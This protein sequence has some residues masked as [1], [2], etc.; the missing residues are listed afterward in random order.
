MNQDNN[1]KNQNQNKNRLNMPRNFHNYKKMLSDNKLSN[2][3]KKTHMPPI[4]PSQNTVNEE[5]IN[6]N[7][8]QV[9]KSQQTN[10]QKKLGTSS[11][12]PKAE[13]VKGTVEFVKTAAK[14]KLLALLAPAIAQIS[15]IFVAALL[16]FII[17]M[18]PIARLTQ[19]GESI[20]GWWANVKNTFTSFCLFCSDEEKAESEQAKRE[21]K[22]YKKINK[23]K[24]AFIQ[25]KGMKG[26]PDNR[27]DDFSIELDLALLVSSILYNEDLFDSNVEAL[28]D[29]INKDKANSNNNDDFNNNVTE[30]NFDSWKENN[31]QYLEDLG[32]GPNPTFQTVKEELS[33]AQEEMEETDIALGWYEAKGDPIGVA[34]WYEEPPSPGNKCYP[35]SYSY[36]TKEDPAWASTARKIAKHMVERT[37][38][39][40]CDLVADYD[41]ETGELIGYHWEKTIE[42][43]YAL[44]IEEEQKLY[45]PIVH[46]NPY[47]AVRTIEE[48]REIPH[49]N[50]YVK[51]MLSTYIP[52]KYTSL[53]KDESIVS[54]EEYITSLKIVLARVYT[55][56]DTYEQWLKFWEEESST[57]IA[58]TG[59]CTYKFT[60][61]E[62]KTIETSNLKVR[63]LECKAPYEP[64]EG[65][66]L[67]DFEKYILGV[68]Y[69]ENGGGYTEALKAQAIAARNFSLK[70]A[71]DGASNHYFSD[72][73]T[74]LNISNCTARQVYCDPDK[75]CWS[76]SSSAGDT[77][78]S[79]QNASKAYS[80]G[81]V[82]EKVRTAVSQVT[83]EVLVNAKGEIIGTPYTAGNGQT[84][85]N[86]MANEGKDYTE[87]LT[88]WYSEVREFGASEII[89]TSCQSGFIAGDWSSWK[90]GSGSP[91]SNIK[92]CNASA[93]TIAQIGCA[94]TSVS[95]LIAGSG[96]EIT[97]P[98][99]NPGTFVK[100]LKQNG[101]FSGCAIV[102]DAP[103]TT[104]IAPNFHFISDV[105]LSGS[106]TQ[107]VNKISSYLNDGYYL[108]MGVNDKH[109]GNGPGHYVAVNNVVNETVHT[110]DPGGINLLQ[111]VGP[112]VTDYSPNSVTRI[113]VYKKND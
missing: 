102:W 105:R 76:N 43:D 75:G 96:T 81:A 54:T 95:I 50:P 78:H 24:K 107:K 23:I 14:K 20:N 63:L 61:E 29:T 12:F 100:H 67:V 19:A 48:I 59:L 83:G 7:Q 82:S 25:G 60:T 57:V 6:Q 71:A 97:V 2:F 33:K 80:K 108:V 113:L 51:Y 70:G 88:Y 47:P 10:K 106:W 3:S 55:Y 39:A 9:E 85:W 53:L 112:I 66:E 94:A 98:D 5:E 111:I 32:F 22:F 90:Q 35:L 38:D 64:I 56:R 110:Y 68:V 65:E 16:V 104:G 69:A 46:A 4:L 34:E 72:N 99:F 87:I 44:R 18:T 30:E 40:D 41:D 37:I 73:Q 62:G 42:Y 79:G 93:G 13:P 45:T 21:E 52:T 49:P 1:N 8:E 11:I 58:G 17:F 26:G 92:I 91:W 15:L 36:S 27:G 31:I 77:V 74:I 101:G 84:Q 86:E 103:R 28:N 109:D 89:K